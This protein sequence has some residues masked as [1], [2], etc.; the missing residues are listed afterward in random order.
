MVQSAGQSVWLDASGAVVMAAATLDEVE[1]EGKLP[2]AEELDVDDEEL[3][4]V[5]EV[6]SCATAVVLKHDRY[7]NAA[8]PACRITEN[9]PM[10]IASGK[11]TA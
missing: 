9:D 6:L 11:W 3:V 2:D 8:R 1:V 5:V 4:F 10:P 7:N